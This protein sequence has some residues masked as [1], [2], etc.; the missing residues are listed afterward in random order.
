MTRQTI[1][2]PAIHQRGA[3]AAELQ[4]LLVDLIDL[5]LQAKQAHWNVVGPFF[6][7]L[8]EQFDEIVND[9][10]M[11][12]D[13]VAERLV[14][15]GEAPDGRVATVA[16]QTVLEAFPAGPIRD[17]DA[18]DAMIGRVEAVAHRT[19]ERMN[20][21]GELDLATQEAVIEILRGLEKHLWML[22]VQAERL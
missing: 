7:P 13:T 12:A 17:R 2:L 21:L 22:R 8:H 4:P 15:I 1:Q 3:V 20:R 14:A 19:R 11:W 6:K 16:T 9:V 18:V 10:R 5:G